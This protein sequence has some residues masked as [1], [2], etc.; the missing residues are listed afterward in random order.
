[1]LHKKR[2]EDPENIVTIDRDM[3]VFFG[4]VPLCYTLNVIFL[5]LTGMLFV[6]QIFMK[7][8]NQSLIVQFAMVMMYFKISLLLDEFEQSLM[9]VLC[10][11]FFA[12]MSYMA[13]F[14]ALSTCGVPN[15]DF[16]NFK[17]LRDENE[18]KIQP[19]YALYFI[20]LQAAMIWSLASLFQTTEVYYVA[21]ALIGYLLYR[22]WAYFDGKG[23]Q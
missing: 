7:V 21:N 14:D 8:E 19:V 22:V 16:Y 18:L 17:V 3:Y 13:W 9:T 10:F 1:M 4:L 15:I 20:S 23:S 2:V 12:V 11:S 6:T 5:C